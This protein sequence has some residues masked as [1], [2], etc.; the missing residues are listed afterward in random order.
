MLNRH[1]RV[2]ATGMSVALV[3]A[4][5]QAQIAQ[6]P[7]IA[8]SEGVIPNIMYVF[9]DSGSMDA[10]AIYQYGG[11]AGGYGMT[12]PGGDVTASSLT[13]FHGRS[14]DVNLIYYDPR[15]T[16]SR[17]INANGT[18]MA[19]GTSP[20][21][22]FNVYFYNPINTTVYKV[23]SVGVTNGG[24]GY[25][26][27]G[28]T[29]YFNNAPAGG[30]TAAA[31]VTTS[32]KQN[33]SSVTVTNAGIGYPASG[34]TVTFS[35]PPSGGI[36]ATGTVNLV[37]SGAVASVAATTFGSGYAASGVTATFSA[38]S[39]GGINATGT[40]VI[41]SRTTV[42][43]VNITNPGTG[44]PT[45]GKTIS[46]TAAPT[47]GVTTQGTVTTGTVYTLTGATVTAGGTGYTSAPT[48]SLS[49]GSMVNGAT[50]TTGTATIATRYN[51]TGINVTNQG[52]NFTS[53][54]T[55]T[56]AGTVGSGGTAASGLSAVLATRYNVSSVNVTAGGSYASA[57]TVTVNGTVGPGG[58]A[59]TAATATL[60]NRHAPTSVTMTN[61]GTNYT[62]APTVTVN[63]TLASGGTAATATATLATLYGVSSV[64][65]SNPGVYTTA[66]SVSFAGTVAPGRTAATGTATLSSLY[67]VSGIS[68]T[69]PGTTSYTSAPTVTVNGTLAGG[70]GVAATATATIGSMMKLNTGTFTVSPSTGSGCTSGT[71]TITF[72][73][74]TYGSTVAT[75]TATVV[76]GKVTGFTISGA[77]AGY[78]TMPSISISGCGSGTIVPTTTSYNGVRSIA[79]TSGSGYTTAPTSVTI[80]G[81]GG[82][83]ATATVATSTYKGVTGVSVTGGTGYTAAPTISFTG[84]TGSG[85]AATVNTS[86]YGAVT[87]VTLSG[88]SGYTAIPTLTFSSGGGSGAA[89]TVNTTMSQT[90]ASVSVTGGT[91]YTAAPTISFSG[92]GG[93]GAGATVNTTNYLAVASISFAGGT[94]Y[95]AAPTISISGGGGSGATATSVTTSYGSVSGV[96]L[97]GGLVGYTALPT[98][99]LTGGGGTGAAATPTSTSAT[100]ITSIT[101]TNPGSG[102]TTTP[103]LTLGG[104]AG[105]SGHS[106]ALVT[107]SS[108]VITGF[109]VTNGGSGYA[110]TPTISLTNTGGGTGATLTPTMGTTRVVGSISL[111]NGGVGYTSAPTCT[112]AASSGSGATCTVTTGTTYV[113]SGVTVTDPGSGYVATPTFKINATSGAG[114]TF[115]VNTTGTLLTGINSQWNG[116][117]TPTAAAS[118]FTPSYTADAGSPLAPGATAI[119][120]PNAASSGISTYPKFKNRTDCLTATTHCTWTEELQNYNNWYTYHRTRLDLAKTGV[121]LAFQ[122]LSGTFRL[123]WASLNTIGSAGASL[124][125]G[126]RK[127]DAATEANFFTWLYSRNTNGNTPSRIAVTNVGNYFL[128]KDDNGPWADD[129]PICTSC[130]TN[131]ATGT[132][133]AN[134]ASCRRSYT[135]FMTDGYYNDS[136]ALTDV[137]STAKTVSGFNYSPAGPFSDTKVG[138]AFNNSFA[139]VAMNYWL[140]DLR[141][142]LTDNLKP[143]PADPATWQHMNF[144]AIGLGLVGTLDAQDPVILNELT[145]TTAR[146]RDWPTPAANSQTAIDDM[147]HATLNGRGLMLN[148][149]NANELKSSILKIISD[150]S[151]KEDSQSGVAV[152]TV[153]LSSDTMKYTPW[154]TPGYWIGDVRAWH[155]DQS[156]AV[157]IC[158]PN[159]TSSNP[160]PAAW[161]IETLTGTDPI[162]GVPTYTSLI[163]SHTARNIV[164]GNG[165]T[166]GA[167]AVNFDF[168]TMTSTGLAAVVTGANANLINY[169]RGDDS[170]E[171]VVGNSGSSSAIYRGRVAKLGDVVNSTP[172][173]VYQNA[174]VDYSKLPAAQGPGFSTYW[175]APVFNTNG[176][177]TAPAGGLKGQRTEG[178]LFVGSNDG[179]L[180]G[181]RN[182]KYVYDAQG[183]VSTVSQ[184][185]GIEAF[186]YVPR[187]ILPKIHLLADKAYAHR[188]FVD[189]PTIEADA[190]ISGGW[191]NIVIGS[192]GAGAGVDSSAGVSPG[193]GIFVLDVTSLNTGI[194]TTP[195]Y[196][197]GT[198]NVLWEIGSKL[199]TPAASE[200]AELGYVL[201]DIQTGPTLDGSWVAIFGNGYESASCKAQLFIVNLSSGALIKKID[202]GAGNCSTAKNGLGGVGVVR[203]DKQQ[204]IGAYAGDLL[205]NM[206]KFD[207]NDT[208]TSN[209]KLGLSGDPLFNAGGTKP[210]TAPPTIIDLADANVWADGKNTSP[211]PGYMVVFGSGK[212]YETSDTSTTTQQSLY[213]AW[214]SELFGVSTAATGAAR[215]AIGSMVQQSMGTPT[216][217]NGTNYF[218]STTNTV[219]YAGKKGWYIDFPNT[220]ERLIYPMDT[221]A[222]HYVGV[223]TVS[224]TGIAL[225]S[226][227]SG[228]G[229]SG[230][231]YVLDALWGGAPSENVLGEANVNGFQTKL[232]GRNVSLSVNNPAQFLYK[233]LTPE[234]N[235]IATVAINKPVPP[236]AAV[237]K[238]RTW[239]QLFPR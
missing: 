70:Y 204:I 199:P 84:G 171:D 198:G 125:A 79:F 117:G 99:A 216:V 118:Y 158:G 96:T 25:P 228:S 212:M 225:N 195:S 35:A 231:F 74:P 194:T 151:G 148:A 222:Y 137:D 97:A 208:S 213:G 142:D 201:T 190:Y 33:V 233:I 26:S 43:G 197:M 121:G 109:T 232:E 165:A 140:R 203:N 32:A 178:M 23:A 127:Y 56:V 105:G 133:N 135:I 36:S 86:S 57:P 42:T 168:T 47:G 69:N 67:Q 170:N 78:T 51:L 110:S 24:S 144:Y 39:A 13:T 98:I 193:T 38:P 189:G 191:K 180:H 27:S 192:T 29:G 113:I 175:T 82:G 215:V 87:A 139:D 160:C 30:N 91:G 37:N 1:F 59:A 100:G 7:L 234:S 163:P 20:N 44:F 134:H 131:P 200:Y 188:Y 104:T 237:M 11:S 173:F 93:S 155:L 4:T 183:N 53:A 159:P 95:T 48:V 40:P 150:V 2:F 223:G 177:Q 181:F 31:T 17:R 52:T 46:F 18:P 166:S 66:P 90:V 108:N 156:S 101:I 202:T 207:L 112:I 102:Y 14:P 206:W 22:A 107:A 28:V 12:G 236:A 218:S 126:V 94:G 220:G 92:G 76:S 224:P 103:T 138:T 68:V 50:A 89:G 106:T 60:A 49:G 174:S 136:F 65:I 54:P 221:M 21:T 161:E 143:K 157:E 129:P 77:G 123:G 115:L 85:V 196:S 6:A 62:S 185:G 41:A 162:S 209:W 239:R 164:V 130:S 8:K 146:V 55:V 116:A 184:A 58:S 119:A 45:S 227:V 186:A 83:G 88:G 229:G 64:G 3:A 73:A 169:L 124:D 122:P 72:G 147:W 16:Y 182:G 132:A 15:V 10:I 211:K 226:C 63:G 217:I 71:R 141:D 19:L 149:R 61:S 230:Y 235:P 153:S 145:G 75:G 219:N 81:G 205:G 120:Y 154:Y 128:R 187:A 167:R 152:S 214:D 34:T 111:T 176:Q 238:T 5:A 114:A 80:S 210:I 172:T 9:D 179:M